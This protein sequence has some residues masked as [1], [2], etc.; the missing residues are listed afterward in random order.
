MVYSVTMSDTAFS[1]SISLSPYSI[2][3]VCVVLYFPSTES[4]TSRSC[5]IQALLTL[6]SDFTLML[7][8]SVHHHFSLMARLRGS[9]GPQIRK[10]V[11]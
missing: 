9:A 6:L 2:F 8:F 10:Q 7:S 3:Y 4:Q 1:S 11:D 5:C